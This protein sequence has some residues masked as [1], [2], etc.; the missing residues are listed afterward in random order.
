MATALQQ[1]SESTVRI[2]LIG[3]ELRRYREAAG[4][5][6]AKAAQRIGC[7][8]TKVSRME[9]GKS[10]QKCEDVAGLLAVYGV[11]GVERRQL[12][13]LTRAADRP[14]LWQRHSSSL[15]QRIA[16]LKLLESRAIRLINFE[17]EVIPGL[18]QTVPY[19]Q[20]VVRQVA[21]VDDEEVIGERV[22]ARIRRQAVLR[23]SGAPHLLAIIA[24]NALQNLIGDRTVMRDQL[25]YLTE[26]AR[27]TNISM[28]IIPNSAGNHPGFE[29]PFLRLQFHDRPGVVILANRT[30]SLYLE[31]D[32]DLTVY[33]K[34]LVELL[35]VALP[36]DE[37][38]AL[39]ARLAATME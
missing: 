8:Q 9:T 16:T 2:R 20:A 10:N 14:G 30:S 19:I 36:E 15:A 13:E 7:D 11:T 29:G 4:F 12:L 3:E 32:E 1:L 22:A 31:D 27:R 17:C 5:S 37:S 6:L 18:L 28:R 26:A 34:V 33:N 38:V 21:L 24:Q 23:K 35:S 25:I 39:V